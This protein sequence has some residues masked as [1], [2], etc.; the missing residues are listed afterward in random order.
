MLLQYCWTQASSVAIAC[1]VFVKRP[2][3]TSQLNTKCIVEELI[4]QLLAFHIL[5]FTDWMND[6]QVGH[7]LGISFIAT[8]LSIL[9]I[10]YATNFLN[11]CFLIRKKG[12]LLCAKNRAKKVAKNKLFKRAVKRFKNRESLQE[13]SLS[14]R[15]LSI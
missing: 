13:P 10:H 8:V 6:V 5:C 9:V 7:S 3:I 4:V 14:S 15:S 11:L 12:R 2:F 1:Y